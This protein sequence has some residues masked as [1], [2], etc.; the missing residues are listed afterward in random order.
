MIEC[1][2]LTS[3]AEVQGLAE[4]WQE[5]QDAYGI[6]PFT[7][8]AWALAWWRTVG[9]PSGASLFVVVAQREGKLVGILPLSIR[10]KKGVRILRVISNEAYYY[11]NFL[12]EDEKV[13]GALWEAVRASDAYDYASIKNIHAG[14]PE[15][16]ALKNFARRIEVSRVFYKEHLGHTRDDILK[17]FTTRFRRK[18]RS[19]HK[20][21]AE[22]SEA[23]EGHATW[24]DFPDDAVPFLVQEKKEWCARKGKRG[25]FQ[26]EDPEGFYRAL[27]ELGIQEKNIHLFWLRLR[28]KLVAVVLS[29]EKGD[30][31]YGHTLAMD[32]AA[33]A[34]VPGLYLTLESI[35]WAAE[36]GLRE[37]NFMEGEEPYKQRYSQRH[38]VIQL[39]AFA[40][41]K[42]GLLFHWAYII[43]QFVRRLKAKMPR[44]AKAEQG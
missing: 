13:M 27:C 34:Y 36:N 3:E 4:A 1:K 38:R 28:G 8:H 7:G 30:T 11:R 26:E 40:R 12:A 20:T 23:Q 6:V 41:T 42:K 22:S 19:T 43:L 5:L 10:D 17:G 16:K 32:P 25:L 29:F 2:I 24:Q 21:I 35:V 44:R 18:M 14:S 31:L 33:G 37:T 39:F 15:E 9:A